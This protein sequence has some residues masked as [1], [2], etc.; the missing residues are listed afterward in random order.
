MRYEV[1]GTRGIWNGQTYTG[2]PGEWG[3]GEM[4]TSGSMGISYTRWVSSR[5]LRYNMVPVGKTMLW[6][7]IF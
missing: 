5:D 1:W 3:E 6:L 7:K 2:A 4:G